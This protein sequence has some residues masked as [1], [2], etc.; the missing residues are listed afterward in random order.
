MKVIP[1]NTDPVFLLRSDLVPLNEDEH[2]IR[3]FLEGTTQMGYA[4]LSVKILIGC[5]VIRDSSCGLPKHIRHDGFKSHI[6]DGKCIL[7]AVFL[8]AFH[9]CELG[10]LPQDADALRWNKTVFNQIDAEK[11]ADP[12][13]VLSTILSVRA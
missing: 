11:V 3:L 6:A 13:G 1:D 9:R 5:Q 12:L 7:G 4:M 10:K 8:T 2:I